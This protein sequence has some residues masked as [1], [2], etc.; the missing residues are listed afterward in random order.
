MYRVVLELLNPATLDD[1]PA[2]I[3]EVV[4]R[5]GLRPKPYT[6]LVLEVDRAHAIKVLGVIFDQI[7]QD[8]REEPGT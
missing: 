4:L 2:G 6:P 3:R 5:A 1:L 7:E 8:T